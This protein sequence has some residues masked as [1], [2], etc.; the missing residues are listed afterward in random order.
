M[1]PQASASLLRSCTHRMRSHIQV[2]GPDQRPL[3]LL[4]AGIILEAVNNDNATT[5]NPTNPPAIIQQPKNKSGRTPSNGNKRG[6]E[7]MQTPKTRQGRQRKATQIVALAIEIPNKENPHTT[8][9]CNSLYATSLQQ[10]GKKMKRNTSKKPGWKTPNHHKT[11]IGRK[12]TIL[13]RGG[14][15][16]GEGGG[17]G[18]DGFAMGER[19]DERRG[20]TYS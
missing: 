17:E 10:F 4:R 7:P 8:V 18:H 5:P 12:D 6:P 15:V 1:F 19:G 16:M 13:R 3:T 11:R 2:T 9:S 14:F 20:V